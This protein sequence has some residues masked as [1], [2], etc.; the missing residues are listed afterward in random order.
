MLAT[1]VRHRTAALGAAAIAAAL[2]VGACGSDAPSA[3]DLRS[4]S[5]P[6]A[7]SAPSAADAEAV[8]AV[9]QKVPAHDVEILHAAFDPQL[10]ADLAEIVRAAAT[11]GHA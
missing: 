11:S 6:S 8:W 9:L 7:E 3:P 10:R 2:G 4:G 1:Q 5:A